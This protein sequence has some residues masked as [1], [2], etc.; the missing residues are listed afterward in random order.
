[1]PVTS[2]LTTQAFYKLAANK[3]DVR[4]GGPLVWK[5]STFGASQE[6]FVTLSTAILDD[7]GGGTVAS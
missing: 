5:P 6:A 7:F 4:A 3:L 2:R 1:M